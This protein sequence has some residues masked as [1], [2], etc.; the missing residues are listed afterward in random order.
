MDRKLILNI[1]RKKPECVAHSGF[2]VIENQ[3]K[4]GFENG[5]ILMGFL[6][7]EDLIQ[8]ERR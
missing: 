3:K 4:L 1:E 2:F 7:V 6:A 5:L 8:I